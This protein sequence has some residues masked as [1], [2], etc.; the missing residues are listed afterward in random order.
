MAASKAHTNPVT[1]GI[2]GAG[3]ISDYHFRALRLLPHLEV[4]A[5]CDLNSRLA[6][7]FAQAKGIQN[8]YSD[9]DK[10]LSSEQ[11]DVVH[12]LTPPHIHFTNATQAIEA[13]VDALIE[14]P[15]CHKVSYCQQLRKHSQAAG[16]AIAVSNNFLYFPVY[17]K[18]VSDLRSGRLG[19]IDQIDIVWNK[20]LGQLK[21]G[22]F[23]AWMLQSPKNILFEVA[24]HSFVHLI[25]LLGQPDEISVDVHDKLELPRGLEFYRRWEIRGWKNNTSIRLR[26]SFIDG[27]PEHYIHV[28]GTNAVARVDFE[29]NTYICQEHTP[30]LLDIDRYANVVASARDS[31]LQ[32]SGTL[33]SFVLSKMGLSKNS[34]P[35]PYSIARTIESFYNSRGGI[36]D[37]RID[38]A[39]SEAAVAL[40]EWIAREADLPISYQMVSTANQFANT[41]TPKSTVLVIGGTGFIGQALVRRLRQEGY[42][43]RVLARNPNSCPS[44]LHN[45][46][47]EFAKGDF[48]D[49]NAV[50]AALDGVR[51]VY[52]LARGNG[53]TWSDYLETDV[54][55]TRQVAELCLKHGIEKLFYASSI[56]IYYAGK[57]TSTIT[58]N[59]EPHQG[60]MRVA[61]YARSKAENER[62]LLELHHKQDLPVTIFRPGVVLGRGGSPYHWGIAAWPYSS[63]CSLY[64]DGNNPLPIVLVDDV[65]DAMVRAIEVPGIEGKSYNLTSTPCITANEYLDEFERQASIKLRRV[66]TSPRSSYIESLLK[67]A[68]KSIGRDPHAAFPSYA[69]CEGRSFAAKFDSSKAEHELGWTP[70]QDRETIIRE[71]IQIPVAEFFQ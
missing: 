16:R 45:L 60:I 65:A 22:P 68:I 53:K 11:L 37:E 18:L 14:K 23:G 15:L 54:K 30:Y 55:P 58:E 31:V 44:E 7:Q 48:A 71:G 61:P 13:G 43:V 39:I 5:V 49:V 67:W 51:Y 47:V 66:P 35:F 4:R 36:L 42:G 40:A 64:G 29:N 56:A 6:Q 34:G 25:H 1:V 10:M 27:Y 59:T 33:A 21:G 3:Y 9:F 63:V 26:F 57:N 20:E 19:Q 17:E 28:R 46:G 24:P 52:H 2:L 70:V 69:D 12:I 8:V 38:P 50:E 41:P 32:A 62:S